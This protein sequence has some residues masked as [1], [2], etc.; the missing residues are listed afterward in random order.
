[1]IKTI[2]ALACISATTL[3]QLDKDSNWPEGITGLESYYQGVGFSLDP[4]DDAE[5]CDQEACND[6]AVSSVFTANFEDGTNVKV[7]ICQENVMDENTMTERFSAIPKFIR[8]KTHY[9]TSATPGLGG[10]GENIGGYS[11]AGSTTIC[12]ESERAPLSLFVHE[13]AHNFDFDA[14]LS[15]NQEWKDAIGS[16]SCVPTEYA[17]TNEIED[18]AETAVAWLLVNAENGDAGCM[19]NQLNVFGSFVPED[20]EVPHGSD[21]SQDGG[22]VPEDGGED[23]EDGGEVPE[24]GGEVPEDGGEVPED[25]GEV[26]EDG[27]EVP[28]DGGEVPEDG[29]EVPEDG[30]EVP[31]DGGEV[32]EDGG[33]V[34]ED[35][36]EVPED[37]GEVPEDG[38]EVPEDGGEV[39]EDGGEVPEDGGEVPED[40]G[41][42]P[43]DGGE[44][45]EDGGEVPEDGGAPE[46][47]DAPEDGGEVPGDAQA[48]EVV[49]EPEN[50]AFLGFR[51]EF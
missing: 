10:C 7:C 22:E 15:E 20:Y 17:K 25:G 2:F 30:G 50:L 13:A 9:L 8:E 3:A 37:G 29:G 21:D 41:E 26:P 5:G 43:E 24:D 32:P 36:G 31:E 44:V 33:E 39:P 18:F 19:G 40:G 35:G 42:V 47:G 27:G 16:D 28:E 12:V 1:M 38:G 45:P 6:G 4:T 34:P 11:S 46:D 49:E 14:Q 23:P 48:P 51:T